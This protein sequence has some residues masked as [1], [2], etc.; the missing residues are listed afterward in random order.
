MRVVALVVFAGSCLSL[1]AWADGPRIRAGQWEFTTTASGRFLPQPKQETETR[2]VRDENVDPV[3]EMT[4]SSQC[5]V[6]KRS[7][8]ATGVTWAMTCQSAAGGPSMQGEGR[9][10][11]DGSTLDG[12]MVNHMT[13][14]GTS[15]EL[16][17]IV[18]KGRRLGDCS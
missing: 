14:D 16:M 13:M 7:T 9:I 10:T 3:Q 8:T 12:E 5:T 4:K 2:C 6:T 1:T 11:A 15:Q 18:W 17:K